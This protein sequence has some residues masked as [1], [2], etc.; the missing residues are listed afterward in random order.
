MEIPVVYR[1]A[2]LEGPGNADAPN[3]SGLATFLVLQNVPK[4]WTAAALLQVAYNFYV[5]GLPYHLPDPVLHL[6]AGQRHRTPVGDGG[7]N[8]H[9][10][11]WW[12]QR[13]NTHEAFGQVCLPFQ[14]TP[15]VWTSYVHRIHDPNVSK[16][17]E[18]VFVPWKR[19]RSRCPVKPLTHWAI[20]GGTGTPATGDRRFK[21]PMGHGGRIGF[22]SGT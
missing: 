22:R 21:P 5:L 16:Q 17:N 12:V 18:Q 9:E 7:M 19:P 8:Q 14:D 13:R 20:V 11:D 6:Q 10:T 4:R 1:T 3:L 15:D 2:R